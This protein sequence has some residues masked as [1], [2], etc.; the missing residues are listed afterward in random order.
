MA[1]VFKIEER[2]IGTTNTRPINQQNMFGDGLE[3]GPEMLAGFDQ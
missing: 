1:D 2:I 3:A